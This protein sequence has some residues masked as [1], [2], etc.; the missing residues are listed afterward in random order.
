MENQKVLLLLNSQPSHHSI[1]LSSLMELSIWEDKSE[2]NKLEITTKNKNKEVATET[3]GKHQLV[4]L[5]SKLQLCSSVVFLI[6]QQLIQLKNSSRPADK[7]NLLESSQ[8][9]KVAR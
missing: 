5:L 9:K 1:K 4:M 8:I 3:A 7:F 2:S 6:T